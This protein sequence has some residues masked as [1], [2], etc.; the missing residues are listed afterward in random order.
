MTSTLSKFKPVEC[1]GLPK[2]AWPDMP[3]KI[4]VDVPSGKSAKTQI[5]I[6]LDKPLAGK[7]VPMRMFDLDAL[8]EVIKPQEVIDWR[9]LQ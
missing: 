6:T 9:N 8:Q 5:T 1:R 4:M 2:G 3:F 7:R